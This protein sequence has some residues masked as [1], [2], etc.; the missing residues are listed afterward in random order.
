MLTLVGQQKLKA[1]CSVRVGFQDRVGGLVARSSYWAPSTCGSRLNR[2]TG[3]DLLAFSVV[4]VQVVE[5]TAACKCGCCNDD[6]DGE[7]DD[8]DDDDGGDDGRD[9]DDGGQ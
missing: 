7:D 4:W 5:A 3:L 8:D 1:L 9:E 2:G 6:D